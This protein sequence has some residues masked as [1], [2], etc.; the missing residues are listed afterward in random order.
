MRDSALFGSSMVASSDADESE[1]ESTFGRF[2]EDDPGRG[3]GRVKESQSEGDE[4]VNRGKEAIARAAAARAT[5]AALKGIPNGGVHSGRESGGLNLEESAQKE[6]QAAENSANGID[7]RES[8]SGA[9][10]EATGLP[11]R[12]SSGNLPEAIE[13]NEGGA[14]GLHIDLTGLPSV[15]VPS[16]QPA[17]SPSKASGIPLRSANLPPHAVPGP[18]KLGHSTLRKVGEGSVTE[19]RGGPAGTSGEAPL[20]KPLVHRRQL[21]TS[22]ELSTSSWGLGSEAS[23]LEGFDV[24]GSGLVAVGEMS[25]ELRLALPLDQVG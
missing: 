9:N 24:H 12:G 7:E 22:S 3:L 20:G 16:S 6:G 17:P 25:K 11:S 15:K 5:V 14:D 1:A 2:R 21:S 10:V 23:G 19:N 8:T 4:S 13:K 18:S